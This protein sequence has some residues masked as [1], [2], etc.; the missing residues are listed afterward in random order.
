M[1]KSAALNMQSS[2]PI[3]GYNNVSYEEATNVPDQYGNVYY[4]DQYGYVNHPAVYGYTYVVPVFGTHY[5]IAVLDASVK[6]LQAIH[7]YEIWYTYAGVWTAN[8]FDIPINDA[9]PDGNQWCRYYGVTTAA[10]TTYEV[11]TP[12]HYNYEITVPAHT[13]WTSVGDLGF[14]TVAEYNALLSQMD[15]TTKRNLQGTRIY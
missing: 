8:A 6:R 13:N 12:G 14:K 9:Y 4:P 5:G 7:P 11:I 3:V 10:Y 2:K 1:R 15:N